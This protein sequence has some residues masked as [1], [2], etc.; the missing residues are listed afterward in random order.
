MARTTE[1]LVKGIIKVKTTIDLAPYIDAATE[2]VTEVCSLATKADGSLYYADARLLLIETWLAAHFYAIF[3]PRLSSVSV[4]QGAV[5]QSFMNKVDLGLNQTTY[6]QQVKLLDTYGGLA[7][8][9]AKMKKGKTP[10]S[11]HWLGKKT[12]EDSN[13]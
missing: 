6:G 7:A 4:G 11:V 12:E 10:V 8:L 5:S 1:A 2:L 3:D 9:D 13:L